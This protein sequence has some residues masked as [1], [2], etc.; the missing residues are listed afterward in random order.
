MPVGDGL[1]RLRKNQVGVQTVFG[2]AVPA[3]RVVPWRGIIEYDPNRTDQDVDTGSIDPVLAPISGAP[4]IAW[5]PTGPVYYND[6]PYRLTGALKGGVTPT[7]GGAAK[8]WTYQV[9]SLTADAYQYFTVESGDDTSATDGIQAYGG[10][11]DTYEETIPE[12]LGPLTFSDGWIFGGANLATDRT[13]ALN[14]DT[15]PVPVMGDETNISLDTAS[16]SM[17][18]SLINN[19]LH[20]AVLRITNNT[21]KKRLANGSNS[22]R[23]YA[24]FARGARVIELVLTFAKE[25]VPISERAT[26]TAAAPSPRYI[27]LNST[28]SSII[29]GSTAY[30]YTREGAF[31]LYSATD[32][33][34][35]GNATLVLTYRAFYDGSGLGY[36]YKATVINGLTA[37]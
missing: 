25:A 27:R 12:D 24:G 30:S 3:T 19:A 6:L 35:A 29:T 8:T 31:R 16:G 36:A 9:A 18:V 26:L 11:I 17:G 28:S 37:L 20:G 22:R 2:T 5:N 15:S 23:K 1:V 14:L 21:D 4:N 32:G 33:E 34:I 13:A 7:G 10:I